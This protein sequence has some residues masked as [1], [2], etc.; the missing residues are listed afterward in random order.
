[1]AFVLIACDGRGMASVTGSIVKAMDPIASVDEI[2][3]PQAT[4]VP[5]PLIDADADLK[6]P[7]TLVV[8]GQL[9]E[10]AIDPW[11]GPVAVPLEIQIPAIGVNAP[12]LG[13]GVTDANVMDAPKGP[14]G[15]PIWRS[16]FW[17]RGGGIPGDVGTA[18]IGG[19][20]NDTAGNPQ[21]FANL[22]DL[23]Q[24]DIITVH[25]TTSSVDIRFIVYLVDVYSAEESTDLGLLTMIFGAGPV[26]GLGPQPSFDGLS[27][28]TLI[29]CAGNFVN[30]HLDQ[31]T[32]V[33]STRIE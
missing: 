5:V 33:Y 10:T 26:A 31:H 24:G 4:L 16:A 3:Q 30:G 25:S 1:M 13:V 17:Y 7:P 9:L 22:E 12:V 18:T 6:Q 21:I 27:H 28:L 8:F 2:G 20:V 11:A 15:D 32:V 29:T 19:H 23:Q 14:I